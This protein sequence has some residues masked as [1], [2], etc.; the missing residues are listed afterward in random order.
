MNEMETISIVE[1][2]ESDNEKANKSGI[3]GWLV[4]LLIYICL[5][6]AAAL[7][8]SIGSFIQSS[9]TLSSIISTALIVVYTVMIVVFVKKRYY[10]VKMA[11]TT[12]VLI[13]LYNIIMF[14]ITVVRM[15]SFFFLFSTLYKVILVV[16]AIDIVIMILWIVYISKSYRVYNT[17]QGN[18]EYYTG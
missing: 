10:F 17:F 16:S 3:E 6:L 8:S 4:V 7:Y 13:T 2:K 12:F 1:E 14:L 5:C 15:S 18:V 11:T 9:I